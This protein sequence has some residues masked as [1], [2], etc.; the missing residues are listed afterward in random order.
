MKCIILAG[1][2]GNSLW[3]LSREKYPKQFMNIRKNRS[4]LQETIAK[5]IPFCDEFII[6]TNKDYHFIVENQMK[7]FQ[8]LRYRCFLE[9]VGKKTAPA[10]ALACMCLNPSE[11][12][13]IVSADQVIEGDDYKDTII[14]AQKLARQGM[15]VTFGSKPDHPHTGYGYIL[16]NGQKVLAF[17]EKPEAEEA[18]AFIADGHY[19]WNS[20]N[21]MFQA[22]AFLHE[23]EQQAPEVYRSCRECLRHLDISKRDVLLMK[24]LT[25]DIP[26]VSVEKAVFEK[27][28]HV[29]V[30]ESHIKWHDIGDLE[31]LTEFVPENENEYIIKENCEDVVVINRTEDHLVVVNGMQ[32]AV[33]INTDDA[34]YVSRKEASRDIKKIM[35]ENGEKYKDFFE[36]HRLRFKSWGTS[37]V[38]DRNENF[39]VKRLIIYPGKIHALHKHDMRSEQWTVVQGIGTITIG[40]ETKDY[41]PK[42]S[43]YVPVGVEH[44]VSNYQ[45]EDL[46]LIEVSVGSEISE[47]DSV[48]IGRRAEPVLGSTSMIRLEPAFK[49][50]LWGGTRLKDVYH[51]KC[52][53]DIVAESWELSA[54]K[55]GQSTVGNGRYKG[56]LFSEYLK[57]IGRDAWGWKCQAFERFPIL[58]KL[59]DAKQPLS[60]QVHPDDEFALREE[61]EYGKNEMWHIMECDEE[62][63]IYYGVNR[64]ITKQELVERIKANTILEVLN[65]IKVHKG[66][67]FFVDAGT[68]HA[69]GP[70]ILLCEIQ[71]NSNCTYRLYDF[72]RKDKYGHYRELHVDKAK[73]V[74]NL[75][76]REVVSSDSAKNIQEF[77]GYELEKLGTCKYFESNKYQVFTETE[78]EMNDASFCAVVILE[79]QGFIRCEDETF[80]FNAADTFFI[81]AGKKKVLVR[82]KCSF[83]ETHI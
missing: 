41:Y 63:Y 62:S 52:D 42:E 82:G 43:V 32:D 11:L 51:K 18:K 48:R 50:Y 15:L 13:F 20:G 71:Q 78:F 68:I 80:K 60:I 76:A 69:I 23:L 33:V 28:D 59:I 55:D 75:T 39:Q 81:P 40:K 26:S 46:I 31:N 49:D 54:H 19:L 72:A 37:E 67:T 6:T 9:E 4:L 45:N 64:D 24:Y 22:G 29:R 77:S 74:S 79:G 38:L 2:K 17:K 34:V 27:S 3:P 65:K 66:D 16:H 61:N 35:E 8:G 56:M 53:Y 7:D 58:I 57:K 44:A 36:N 70:G 14:E 30:I 73:E 83:I 21:C 12:V 10:I 5:N 1:G 47:E 25:R